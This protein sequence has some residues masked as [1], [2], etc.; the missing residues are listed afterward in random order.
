MLI[1]NY[2]WS[3]QGAPPTAVDVSD[4]ARAGAGIRVGEAVT[5]LTLVR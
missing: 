3:S 1:R 2:G 5:L 4:G